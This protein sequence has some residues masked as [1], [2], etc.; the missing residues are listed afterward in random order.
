MV[1]V[2]RT[3]LASKSL[4]VAPLVSFRTARTSSHDTIRMYHPT[5]ML[6]GDIAARVSGGDD[7]EEE[8]RLSREIVAA[9]IVC[10]V[11]LVIAITVALILVA[12]PCQ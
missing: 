6:P 10:L 5:P 9:V 7:D 1:S 3:Y 8:A 2:R 11:V 12:K 4:I